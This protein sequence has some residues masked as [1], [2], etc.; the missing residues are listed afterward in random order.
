MKEMTPMRILLTVALIIVSA[1]LLFQSLQ[2]FETNRFYFVD[3]KTD[4]FKLS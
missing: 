2:V 1:F 3:G 4:F